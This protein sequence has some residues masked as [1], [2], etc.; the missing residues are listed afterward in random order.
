MDRIGV[1]NVE[2][3]LLTS[4]KQLS[5]IDDL[6][7]FYS[8]IVLQHNPPPIQKFFLSEILKRIV[9]GGACLFQ[10]PSESPNYS[11]SAQDFLQGQKYEM[12][13]HCLPR[14]LVLDLLNDRG[15]KL[16]DIALDSWTGQFG[17]YTYFATKDQEALLTF[18]SMEKQDP[19]N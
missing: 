18:G 14:H 16:R 3:I 5:E 1:S 17:S 7:F 19:T 13:M 11:F 8:V 2:T 12:D 6:S 10:V 9:P 4:P 15:F